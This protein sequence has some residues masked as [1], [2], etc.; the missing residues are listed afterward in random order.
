MIWFGLI[1]TM[2][3]AGLSILILL[4]VF[5]SFSFFFCLSFVFLSFSIFFSLVFNHGTNGTP[6][7]FHRYIYF[8]FPHSPLFSLFS[9]FFAFFS[10]FFSPF[11]LFGV[12]CLLF[13]IWM[14]CKAKEFTPDLHYFRKIIKNSET[15]FNK[16][17]WHRFYWTFHSSSK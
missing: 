5:L 8:S 12:H 11:D 9:Y 15:W 4:F 7:N 14:L 6:T 13:S 3:S 16:K 2:Q 1:C 10:F 17:Q